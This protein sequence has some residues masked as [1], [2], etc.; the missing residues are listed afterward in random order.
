MT[1]I[2]DAEKRWLA[3][4]ERDARIE[5]QATKIYEELWR[6]VLADVNTAKSIDRF[7]G[8]STNGRPLA[9]IISFPVDQSSDDIGVP[10]SVEIE[11]RKG[12]HQIVASIHQGS[13]SIILFDI[14]ICKA[15]GGACLRLGGK[16]ISYD[17]AS[18]HI[19]T[20]FLYPGL[21]PIDGWLAY[22]QAETARGK[23]AK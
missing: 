15:D 14:D 22:A 11:L 19:L 13:G 10:R 16:D 8:L 9:H 7:A 2:D 23:E 20:A 18:R 21:K 5:E 1:W 12:D 6:Q 17:D 3:E 4:R